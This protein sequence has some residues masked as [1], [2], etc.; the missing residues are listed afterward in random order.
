MGKCEEC[1]H[2]YDVR[3]IINTIIMLTI[4]EKYKAK[5]KITTIGH[6][7]MKTIPKTIEVE[8]RMIII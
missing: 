5:S 8:C 2:K 1:N 4:R 7:R 6:D 3:T